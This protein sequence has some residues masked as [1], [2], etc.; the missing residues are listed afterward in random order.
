MVALKPVVTVVLH[1]SFFEDQCFKSVKRQN[2]KKQGFFFDCFK[3]MIERKF[4]P[5]FVNMFHLESKN[6]GQIL[7]EEGKTNNKLY[8]IEEGEVGVLYPGQ[9]IDHKTC[10][11]TDAHTLVSE[12]NEDMFDNQVKLDRRRVL[13]EFCGATD[14]P[15]QHGG[16]ETADS[17][18]QH[19]QQSV[20]GYDQTPRVPRGQPVPNCL[21]CRR[22]LPRKTNSVDSCWCKSST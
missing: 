18:V 20:L 15:V 16:S 19:R 4:L 12:A 5:N 17:A 22:N 7:T 8:I 2:I 21:S 11:V 1:K 10:A 6:R 13:P 14:L 9:R 3:L